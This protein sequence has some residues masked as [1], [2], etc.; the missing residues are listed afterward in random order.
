MGVFLVRLMMQWD[1]SS[2]GWSHIH[3]SWLL[4]MCICPRSSLQQGFWRH[5]R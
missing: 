3:V 4:S 2:G 5:T 1:C